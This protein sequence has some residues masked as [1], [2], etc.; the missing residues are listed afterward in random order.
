[1]IVIGLALSEAL[2]FLSKILGNW[3]VNSDLGLIDLL[4]FSALVLIFVKLR[5][6]AVLLIRGVNFSL[7]RKLIQSI[8]KIKKL[9]NRVYLFTDGWLYPEDR[10]LELNVNGLSLNKYVFNFFLTFNFHLKTC[11]NSSV[12]KPHTAL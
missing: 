11:V 10:I 12:F 8:G 4:C 1:M 6:R 2:N 5:L 7:N 3:K 9:I